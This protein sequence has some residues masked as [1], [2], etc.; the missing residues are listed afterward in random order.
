MSLDSTTQITWALREVLLPQ[1]LSTY[2]LLTLQGHIRLFT[3]AI[4]NSSKITGMAGVTKT[5]G[6]VLQGDSVRKAEN[7]FSDPLD[8][9]TDLNLKLTNPTSVPGS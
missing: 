2:R 5:W 8:R 6:I 3:L 1:G 9:S 4:H 7:H